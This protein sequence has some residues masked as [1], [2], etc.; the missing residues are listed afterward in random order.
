MSSPPPPVPRR[1]SLKILKKLKTVINNGSEKKTAN[2]KNIETT[3]ETSILPKKNTNETIESDK[4]SGDGILCSLPTEKKCN[5]NGVILSSKRE[6][7]YGNRALLFATT[8]TGGFFLGSDSDGYAVLSDIPTPV[9]FTNAR[10]PFLRYGDVVRVMAHNCN[11]IG[12]TSNSWMSWSKD[13]VST[14]GL[15]RITPPEGIDKI[16]RT[17]R[18]GA[19]VEYGMPF[20]LYSDNWKTNIIGMVNKNTTKRLALNS[21]TKSW[22]EP[23]TFMC[24]IYRSE[25]PKKI[26]EAKLV[27]K[28][29]AS[30]EPYIS[31]S[32]ASKTRMLSTSLSPTQN[33]DSI[34]SSDEN[35]DDVA[36]GKINST[37]AKKSPSK[38]NRVSI[39]ENMKNTFTK[40][41]KKDSSREELKIKIDNIKAMHSQLNKRGKTK[42]NEWKKEIKKVVEMQLKAA[43]EAKRLL[44]EDL[45]KLSSNKETVNNNIN[46][47]VDTAT[48]ATDTKN[49]DSKI[50]RSEFLDIENLIKA[51]TNEIIKLKLQLYCPKVLRF[52]HSFHFNGYFCGMEDYA[53][54]QVALSF[55]FS[56]TSATNQNPHPQVKIQL[57]PFTIILKAFGLKLVTESNEGVKQSTR[58]FKELT[59]NTGIVLDTTLKFCS[60]EDDKKDRTKEEMQKKIPTVTASNVNIVKDSTSNNQ[61]KESVE[62]GHGASIDKGH[63]PAKESENNNNDDDDKACSWVPV[64]YRCEVIK[65]M[66]DEGKEGGFIPGVVK[67]LANYYLPSFVKVSFIFFIPYPYCTAAFGFGNNKYEQKF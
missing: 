44:E 25:E 61:N 36:L 51:T 49:F 5:N 33:I 63:P 46:D 22:L 28:S 58:S 17:F 39:I 41:A 15:Y 1:P 62:R 32:G 54:Q 11:L 43:E 40:A 50:D 29:R 8:E 12:H 34:N 23:L 31:N 13:V 18:Y 47:N 35:V 45:K 64:S 53:I 65:A 60:E 21:T 16:T 67:K 66:D 10:N 2:N 4:T 7:Y 3:G 38:K 57:K 6:I 20:L 52:N 56:F 59:I 24:Q 37:T 30:S 55:H 19:P 48:P 9:C 27:T 26:T 14:A 42:Q